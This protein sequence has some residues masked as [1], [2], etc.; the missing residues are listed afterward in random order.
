RADLILAQTVEQR[1]KLRA[2]VGVDSQVIPMA[3]RPP[4]NGLPISRDKSA[5]PQVMWVARILPEKR[6]HWLLEVARGCPK[7]HFNIVGTANQASQYAVDIMKEAATI[8]NVKVH[9]RLPGNEL[10]KLYATSR[11]LC[12]TS[13][14]EGFPTTFLES[15][16]C[17]MPVVT[18]F[19]PDG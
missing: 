11:I 3:V 2:A 5:P 15:W 13:R 10:A 9:G 1:E 6:L 4:T 17:G 14:A 19:D 7:Y 16:S 12:C 18:C 8:P